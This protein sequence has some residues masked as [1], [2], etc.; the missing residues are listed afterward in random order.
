[1]S[2]NRLEP[3]QQRLSL[4]LSA[5]TKVGAEHEPGGL[6]LASAFLQQQTTTVNTVKLMWGENLPGM[7][8]PVPGN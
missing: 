3:E 1:M 2:I 8:M 6:C 7:W 4:L 5:Y